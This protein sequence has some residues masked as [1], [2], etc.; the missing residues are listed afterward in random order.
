MLAALPTLQL[1]FSLLIFNS[2]SSYSHT[3]CVVQ[4]F[5]V[6]S[7]A[8]QSYV[9]QS[10][11]VHRSFPRRV[12]SYIHLLYTLH[13]LVNT[14]VTIYNGMY[15]IFVNFYNSE[16]FEFVFVILLLF[17]SL[18]SQATFSWIQELIFTKA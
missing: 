14:V 2:Y 16:T 4:N 7:Y 18:V 13:K 12:R 6:Q 5:V 9:V 8:V 3:S 1:P 10:Y 15:V 17:L 11:A